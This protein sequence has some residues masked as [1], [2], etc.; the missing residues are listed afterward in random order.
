[1][2]LN[3]TLHRISTIV[4]TES[5]PLRF[6]GTG[7]FYSRLAPG[8]GDGPQWR[9]IEDMWLVTNRHVLIPRKGEQES[10][11]TRVTFYLRRFSDSGVFNWDP[12]AVRVDDI[13]ELAK[14]HPD[15]SIDVAVLDISEP[16]GERIK[17]DKRFF[18]P[19]FLSSENLAGK[20]NIE[21]E[22]SSDVLV[23]GYPKGFYDEANLFPIVKSGIIASRW[24]V[25]FQGNPYFLIDARLFPGSSGSVV[26][27]KPVDLVVRDGR[28]ISSKEKQFAFLGV[29]SGEPK[30]EEDPVVIGDLTITQT[31]GFDLGIAWYAHLV[32][33]I[34]DNG[35]PLLQALNP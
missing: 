26:L 15:A 28:L 16:V 4:Q 31:S 32:E 27:S 2:N 23:V 29:F 35:V 9:T 24:G 21:V 17:S 6:Q 1:M 3:E 33:D 19:Y 30:Y 22:A 7:F 13:R 5:G 25:G 14:F 10:S 18:A 8:E 34:L 20:N 12:I 11:P